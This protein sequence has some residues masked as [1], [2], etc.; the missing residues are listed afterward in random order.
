VVI[1]DYLDADIP[2]LAR[3]W[4]RRSLGYRAIGFVLKEEGPGSSLLL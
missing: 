2:V 1:H 4:K 3:M